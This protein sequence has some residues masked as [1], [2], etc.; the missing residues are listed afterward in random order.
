MIPAAMGP[1]LL[2]AAAPA[3]IPASVLFYAMAGVSVLIMIAATA[4]A[5]VVRVHGPGEEAA[6]EAGERD[7]DAEAR[8]LSGR[9]VWPQDDGKGTA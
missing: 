2:A 9:L 4:V 3:P 6:P 1:P 7:W 5:I 8:D